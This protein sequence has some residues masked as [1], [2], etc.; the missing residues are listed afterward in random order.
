MLRVYDTNTK[1]FAS[2]TLT[3]TGIALLL[4]FKSCIVICI[5]CKHV[6]NT[7]F[8]MMYTKKYYVQ[9]QIKHVNKCHAKYRM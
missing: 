3:L 8:R 6:K 2:V 4:F 5:V 7:Q 1:H 9:V